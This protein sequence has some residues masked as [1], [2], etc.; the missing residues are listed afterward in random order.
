MSKDLVEIVNEFRMYLGQ[1]ADKTAKMEE[2]FRVNSSGSDTYNF[3]D[4]EAVV[5][6]SAVFLKR[7][8]IS[9]L[10]LHFDAEGN[11]ELNWREFCRAIAPALS[12]RRIAMIQKVWAESLGGSRVPKDLSAGEA[13]TAAEHSDAFNADGH[14]DV[15]SGA[16]S[17]YQISLE[18]SRAMLFAGIQDSISREQFVALYSSISAGMPNDDDLFVAVL[19]G[20]YG[21]AED[22]ANNA[23]SADFLNKVC[24]VLWEKARQRTK[25]NGQESETIRRA[26]NKLDLDD[27]GKLSA[28][29]F[30]GGLETFGIVLNDAV[31]DALFE[32]YATDGLV[33][34]ADFAKRACEAGSP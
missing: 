10:Y 31:S 17:G 27:Q 21:V 4:F 24:A 16:K 30:R 28:E 23:V 7:Q 19:S 26:L 22:G 34:I 15:A 25:A 18:L 14:P 8:D 6:K 3:E 20:C 13:C 32:A 33:D 29:I 5:N 1:S 9:K 11:E 2:C 12:A